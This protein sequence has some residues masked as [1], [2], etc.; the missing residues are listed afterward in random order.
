MAVPSGAIT[1]T[2]VPRAQ[3]PG[4][5]CTEGSD[6]TGTPNEASFFATL[7]GDGAGVTRQVKT[8]VCGDDVDVFG[9]H[10][11][12]SNSTLGLSVDLRVTVG[13]RRVVELGG[14][15]GDPGA[16]FCLETSFSGRQCAPLP[17][18]T[19]TAFL[20]VSRPDTSANDSFDLLITING[21]ATTSSRYE[22]SATTPY[23]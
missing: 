9:L 19:S 22:I 15:N 1:L 3:E 16:T 20:S 8:D 17:S 10:V 2:C 21:A 13:V 12:E 5:V 7:A 6:A 14:P 18:G 11:V 23:A 4:T